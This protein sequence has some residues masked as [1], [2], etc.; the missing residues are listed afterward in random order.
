M[1]W[2]FLGLLQ[3]IGWKDLLDIGMAS[4]LLWLGID[5]LRRSRMRFVGISLLAFGALFLVA[6]ELE[7]KLTVWLLQGLAAIIVLILIIV[8]QSEIRLLLERLSGRLVGKRTPPLSWAV[9][10]ILCEGVSTLSKARRG[11]LI[12]LPASDPLE[13]FTTEGVSLNGQL[14]LPLLLSIFDPNSPGHDGALIIEGSRV[15]R[16]GVHLPLSQDT[17]QLRGRGTRH[18]AALGLAE[19]T[20]ALILVVSEETGRVSAARNG[21]LRPLARL[22]DLREEVAGFYEE[23][24]KPW[25][26]KRTPAKIGK[27][28]LEGALAI[29]LALVFWLFLVPGSEIDSLVHKVPIKIEN[30]PADF[31]LKE[32]TPAEVS[33][34]LAGPRRKLFLFDPKNLNIPVDVTLSRFG[35]Q[36]F[37][38]TPSSILLPRDLYVAEIQPAQIKVYVETKPPPNGQQSG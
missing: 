20:D 34:T 36:T 18:A 31:N 16:F 24:G 37:S 13:W 15:E 4:L 7:I 27:T 30:V 28:S 2:H 14:T 32:V 12:V 29:F 38:L 11:A 19:K 33:V 10:E 21:T 17:E 6:K 23:Q 9:P 22:K 5:A 8:F 1:F 25:V 26:Q 3:E 35:R